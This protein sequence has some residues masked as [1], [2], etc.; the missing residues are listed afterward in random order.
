MMSLHETLKRRRVRS[1]TGL[2][3]SVGPDITFAEWEL[4]TRSHTENKEFCPTPE[5]MLLFL[6]ALTEH[7][8]AMTRVSTSLRIVRLFCVIVETLASV[9]TR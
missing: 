8:I 9:N 6:E 1:Y 2:T 7:E 5:A 4:T 3:S